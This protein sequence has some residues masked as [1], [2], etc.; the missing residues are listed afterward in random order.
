[1][2]ALKTFGYEPMLNDTTQETMLREQLLYWACMVEERECLDWSQN[3]FTRWV[4]QTN[5]DQNNP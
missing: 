1:M 5:P 3:Y 2:P 4:N